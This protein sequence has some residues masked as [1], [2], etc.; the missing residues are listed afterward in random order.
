[1]TNEITIRPDDPY[2][3]FDPKGLNQALA[4][5]DHFL[6]SGSM[7]SSFRNSSQVL[8]A[9]QAGRE[10]G[11]KPIEALNSFYI[12]NGSLKLWGTGLTGQL[13]KHGFKIKWI[14]STEEKAVVVIVDKNGEETLPEAYTIQDATKAGL[15]TKLPWKAHPRTMLR[16][17]AISNAIKFNHPEV[18]SG[19]SIVE[20]DDTVEV[21]QESQPKIEINQN[22]DHPFLNSAESSADKLVQEEQESGENMIIDEQRELIINL[23]AVTGKDI[24]SMLNFYKKSDLKKFTYEEGE[25]VIKMLKHSPE[26]AKLKAE[27]PLPQVEIIDD[28]GDIIK[29]DP[30]KMVTGITGGTVVDDYGNPVNYQATQEERI[31]KQPPLV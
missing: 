7:P 19:L 6:K 16:W 3:I 17:R 20:D 31:V 25:A 23:L 21:S 4:V 18:L 5:A 14:E 9:F 12:V 11:M 29:K 1:M 27:A 24:V 30:V 15:L 28:N 10:L 2:A 8:M 22:E 13:A 26:Y